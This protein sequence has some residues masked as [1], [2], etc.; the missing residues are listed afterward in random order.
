MDLVKQIAHTHDAKVNDVLLAITTGGLRGLLHSRGEPIEGEGED[1]PFGFSA[2][3]RRRWGG[4]GS[5]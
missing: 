4:G 3:R 5:L 1:T 2:A